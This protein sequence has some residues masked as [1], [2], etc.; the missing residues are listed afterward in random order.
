[1]GKQNRMTMMDLRILCGYTGTIQVIQEEEVGV[2][3]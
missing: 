3:S 2:K 1:M